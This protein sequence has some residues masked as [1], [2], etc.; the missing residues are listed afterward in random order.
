[1]VPVSWFSFAYLC[2][3]NNMVFFNQTSV[4]ELLFPLQSLPGTYFQFCI[5]EITA[6]TTNWKLNIP[7]RQVRHLCDIGSSE[8]VEALLH[9]L[10][11]RFYCMER[12]QLVRHLPLPPEGAD[13]PSCKISHPLSE[14]KGRGWRGITSFHPW[15]IH[16]CSLAVHSCLPLLIDKSLMD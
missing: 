2:T 16:H 9:W 5:T 10:G 6:T 11:K 13:E 14:K 1:M 3:G 4:W 12:V 15:N 7:S 8:V